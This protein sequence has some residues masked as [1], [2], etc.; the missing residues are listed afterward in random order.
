M[1]LLMLAHVMYITHYHIMSYP[2]EIEEQWVRFDQIR[3]EIHTELIEAGISD[4]IE[5]ND[6]HLVGEPFGPYIPAAWLEAIQRESPPQNLQYL[7]DKAWRPYK[8]RK[9]IARYVVSKSRTYTA[10]QADIDIDLDPLASVLATVNEI[11]VATSTYRED[12]ATPE[13]TSLKVMAV[14]EAPV[15]ETQEP[16]GIGA[17]LNFSQM[18]VIEGA[19]AKLRKAKFEGDPKLRYLTKSLIKID[20]AGD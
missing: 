5:A 4:V 14:S 11:G 9:N 20:S 17:Y 8:D 19:V 1:I 7:I 18:A 10:R 16:A 6:I 3:D 2:E 15:G 13:G 12:R